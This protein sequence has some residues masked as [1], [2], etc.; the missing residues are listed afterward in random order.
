MI[1]DRYTVYCSSKGPQI[2]HHT[3]TLRLQP[4]PPLDGF[5]REEPRD[6]FNGFG[7]DLRTLDEQ[8]VVGGAEPQHAR[9]GPPDG[10]EEPSLWGRVSDQRQNQFPQS[11]EQRE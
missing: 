7:E 6:L 8:L 9:G 11:G 3:G 1:S 10:C 5:E 2:R 4:L